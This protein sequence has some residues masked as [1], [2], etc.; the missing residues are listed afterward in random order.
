MPTWLSLPHKIILA[1]AL[2]ASPILASATDAGISYNITINSSKTGEKI[3]FT[4]H[5]PSGI[6]NGRRYPL[7]LRG[8]G[9]GQARASARSSVQDY[10]DAGFGVIAFDQRGFGE[11]ETTI[12][13]MD[14]ALDG[15]N[16]VEIVDWAEQRLNWL[17]YKGGKLRLGATGS[18]Y[19]GG[20]QLSL[21]GVD[22]KQRLQAIVPQITWNDLSYS[23][24]PGGVP[25]TAYDLALTAI[26]TAGSKAG[27]EPYI[28]TM[29]AQGLLT[30]KISARDAD[31]LRYH[32]AKYFCDGVTRAGGVPARQ[33][34]KVDVLLMQG[35]YDALFNV[36]EAWANYQCLSKSGGDVRLM[37]YQFGHILPSSPDGVANVL[38]LPG[39]TML[40]TKCGKVEAITAEIAW[41]KAKLM[42]Q[43]DAIKD[44]PKVCVALDS[45]EDAIH[46][47]TL[48]VG[49]SRFQVARTVV[50]PSMAGIAPVAI[51]LYTTESDKVI[52][53]IPTMNLDVSGVFGKLAQFGEPILFVG[54]GKLSPQGVIEPV[55][56]QIRPIRGWGKHKIDLNGIGFRSAK[57]Q[58]VYLLVHGAHPQFA[59]ASSRLASPAAVVSGTVDLPVIGG[60]KAVAISPLPTPIWV[61][62]IAPVQNTVQTVQTV[63]NTI[64]S[65]FRF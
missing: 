5:E 28:T 64:K 34:P 19:G 17:A 54:I 53:G 9:F 37:T 7:L 47:A 60:I 55:G 3:F 1:A 42:D 25:K 10:V 41:L 52:A 20:Y 43:P 15:R 26:G 45:R 51:P 40:S 57:G 18:S 44:L 35:M 58:T 27:F 11:S 8:A 56:D 33:F 31:T 6:Q 39:T 2:L 22:P 13:V 65:W 48:P 14:P 30:N 50:T 59:S 49:G 38:P 12:T 36:N 24:T 23:L 32:S 61:P 29:L 4:V 63:A 46:M 16:L 62:A 21:L